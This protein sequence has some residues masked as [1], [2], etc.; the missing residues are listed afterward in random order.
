MQP[1]KRTFGALGVTLL[2]FC[3]P[4]AAAQSSGA[5]PTA[6]AAATAPAEVLRAVACEIA[7]NRDAGNALL[8]TAPFSAEE[9]TQAGTLL[10]AAQRCLRLPAPI[11][12]TSYSFRGAVAEAVYENRFATPVAARAPA[13]GAAPLLRPAPGTDAQTV[14]ILAPMYALVDCAAPRQPDLARALLATEPRSPEETVAL[15]AF[16]PAF[17]ACVPAGTQLRIDPRIMRNLFAEALYRWS[18]VQRDGPTSPWAAAA[19]SAPQ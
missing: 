8:A 5:S 18:V 16:N 19:A 6:P 10:R 11:A 7:R 9:R 17:I 2:A 3:G 13:L 15:T 1:I 12:V 4:A 14:E